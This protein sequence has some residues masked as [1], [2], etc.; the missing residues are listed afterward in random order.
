MSASSRFGTEATASV[1]A[2]VRRSS[3]PLSQSSP[4]LGAAHADDGH[5][6]AYAFAAHR[7]TL[8]ARCV[9]AGPVDGRA[10]LPEVIVHALRRPDAPEGH[11]DPVADGQLR[12]DHV[13]HFAAVAAATV[14][15]D[16]D[17]DHRRRQAE[18]QVVDG[19][20]GHRPGDVG[21][22]LGLHLVD[23][24][25]RQAGPGRRHVAEAADLATAGDEGVLPL[26]GPV[27]GR[28]RRA[29]RGRGGVGA[30]GASGRARSRRSHTAGRPAPPPPARPP[31]G[32]RPRPGPPAWPR[33]RRSSAARRAS[34]PSANDSTTITC[35]GR[36][37]SSTSHSATA[38]CAAPRLPTD[39]ARSGARTPSRTP[40]PLRD[41]LHRPHVQ[42][43]DDGV[44]DVALG[45][46]RHP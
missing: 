26:L 24:V 45:Q 4:K 8:L 28:A 14:E 36:A 44:V 37:R 27:H 2:S 7:L 38:A 10:G 31:T 42:P 17:P 32:L 16:D 33:A 34:A 25:T 39:P 15:V 18:G 23:G 5:L 46:R 6:V 29:A 1:V 19:E 41:S 22:A 43:A 11:G 20:R 9:V 12:G 40:Q 13:R 21:E 3:T 30:R 35:P